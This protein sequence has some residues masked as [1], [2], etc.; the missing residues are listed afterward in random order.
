MNDVDPSSVA[1]AL[2]LSGVTSAEPVAGG[3]DTAVWHIEAATG[4]CALRVFREGH[5]AVCEREAAV[6]EALVAV[7]YP[8]PRVHARGMWRQRPALLLSWI[9]GEP[10]AVAVVRRPDRAAEIGAAFGRTQARLHALAPRPE[11]L[12]CRGSWIDWSGPHDAG[13]VDYLKREERSP[14]VIHL[15]FHVMNVMVDGGRISG[16]L[17]WV[18]AHLGDARAD[19]ARSTSILLL[20]MG[21]PAEPPLL[22]PESVWRTFERAWR[23]GYEELAGPL[24]DLAPWY[25]WAGSVMQHDLADRHSTHELRHVRQWTQEWLD[26]AS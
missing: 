6:M 15:D 22:H 3:F 16:V 9:P 12:R 1:Q 24:G 23:R 11:A 8:V 20:D 17:D 19:V 21:H 25:A 14:C 7:G 4:P 2:G 5:D 13:L 10:V 26:K 18:N